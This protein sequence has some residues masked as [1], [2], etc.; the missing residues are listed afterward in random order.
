[1]GDVVTIEIADDGMGVDASVV[2]DKARRAGISLPIGPLDNAAL[3]A[4]LCSS[5]FTTRDEADRASGRG[6]G[7]AVVKET[8]EEL[9][10]TMTLQTEPGEGTRFVIQLPVTLAITDALI[11]RVGR[12]AFAIPQGSVR[13]VI[14]VPSADIRQLEENEIVPYREGALPIIRL[15]RVFGIDAV[16]LEHFH[17]FVVGSGADLLGLAVDRIIGQREIVVRTVADP[18]VRVDGISGATDLGDGRVV[19]I[20]DP[21]MLSRLTKQR[22]ARALGAAATWGR[23]RA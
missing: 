13:E 22:A 9:S 8:V 2:A 1:V 18:L 20:L 15:A 17:V 4:L 11:G 7:M 23:V 6:V 12:E 16:P 3:L 10:G 21:A 5:G 19:L 14:D